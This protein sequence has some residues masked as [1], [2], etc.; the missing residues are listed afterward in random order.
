MN[1]IDTKYDALEDFALIDELS[2]LS[3]VKV[4]KAIEEI[5]TAPVLHH[6]VCAK[7]MMEDS[8][9]NVLTVS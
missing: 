7:D 4:P 9:R 1:A 8:V 2:R 6:T 3:G 5:R